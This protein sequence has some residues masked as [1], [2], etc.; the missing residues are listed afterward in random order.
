MPRLTYL[1]GLALLLL[2]GASLLTDARTSAPCVADLARALQPF[3]RKRKRTLLRCSTPPG[4]R[5]AHGDYRREGALRQRR[6]RARV[7]VRRAPRQERD[8]EITC[9]RAGRSPGCQPGRG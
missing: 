9:R 8:L 7:R 6:C 1:T 3:A 4:R 5:E 2:A